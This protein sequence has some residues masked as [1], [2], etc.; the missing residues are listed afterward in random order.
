[1]DEL[2][3]VPGVIAYFEFDDPDGHR[4]SCYTEA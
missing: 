2:I 1:M 3:E 4:L